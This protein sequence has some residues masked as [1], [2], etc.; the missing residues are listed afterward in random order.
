MES[1]DDNVRERFEALEQQTE[2]LKQLQS[3]GSRRRWR[4][5]GVMVCALLVALVSS[6]AICEI[7][8]HVLA[9]SR[10]GV[11]LE[12]RPLWVPDLVLGYRGN[13]RYP[14]H[15]AR[16]YR[17]SETLSNA[18]IVT[19]GDSHTYGIGVERQ[20]AWPALLPAR[21]GRSV[22][23]MAH[24]GYGPSQYERMLPE[25]LTLRPQLLIV[26]LYMGNDFYDAYTFTKGNPLPP[27]LTELA[28]R[29]AAIDNE[30]PIEEQ[31]ARLWALGRRSPVRA[32]LGDHVRLYRLAY[33][34]R[35]RITT[36]SALLSQN[37]ETAVAALTPESRTYVSMIDGPGWRTILRTP[38]RRLGMNQRDPRILLGFELSVAALESIATQCR[39][40]HVDLL[41]VVIPTKES[42]FWPRVSDPDRHPQGRELVEDETAFRA[43]LVRR[44]HDAHI[45]VLDVLSALQAAMTQP[46][47]E[48]LEDHP[49]L[50]GHRIIA[51]QVAGW[52]LDRPL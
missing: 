39:L 52:V 35:Q 9:A 25:A 3:G 7:V 23:S 29:A 4:R 45:A 1:M 22:Y 44:L 31:A 8:L 5:W 18:D 13:P 41:V 10:L 34:V 30:A 2:Q 28:A 21:I 16:G 48:N 12:P 51:E 14:D 24:G 6:L 33:H 49:N 47:P 17:N 37:F 50:A 36:P 11:L 15:D 26:G 46:Y 38:H 42:V 43:R 20:E 27:H 32:W 19:I 40:E